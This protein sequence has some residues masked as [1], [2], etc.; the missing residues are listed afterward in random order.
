MTVQQALDVARALKR[1]ATTG[2]GAARLYD[3]VGRTILIVSWAP[4]DDHACLL[5]PETGPRGA[6]SMLTVPGDQL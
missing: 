1:A 4:Q 3:R 5:I 6:E 2:G